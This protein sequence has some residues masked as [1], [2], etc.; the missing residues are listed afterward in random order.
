[1]F[2]IELSYLHITV[3]LLLIII[4]FKSEFL[5]SVLRVKLCLFIFHTLFR[6]ALGSKK[7][8]NFKELKRSYSLNSWLKNKTSKSYIIL[9]PQ[10]HKTSK[11][12]RPKW[13]CR[14]FFHSYLEHSLEPRQFLKYNKH[15]FWLHFL[16]LKQFNSMNLNGLTSSWII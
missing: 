3:V 5:Y 13:A 16:P 12:L 6:W 11:V 9:F 4:L 14:F 8:G 1:M 10:L 2:C 15:M 7:H